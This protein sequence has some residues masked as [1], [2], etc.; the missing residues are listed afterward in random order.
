MFMRPLMTTV[1][2]IFKT[3]RRTFLT[4]QAYSGLPADVPLSTPALPCPA[5]FANKAQALV[6]GQVSFYNEA[7]AFE[8]VE[9]LS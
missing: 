3:C 6:R 4:Q 7:Q 2:I 8:L 9:L 5:F 1:F